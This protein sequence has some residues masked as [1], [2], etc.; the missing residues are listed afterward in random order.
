MKAVFIHSARLKRLLQ[1]QAN[2]KSGPTG[3]SA[4]N[5]DF[6]SSVKNWAFSLGI[7][8]YFIGWIYLHI[9]YK[10][11]GIDLTGLDIPVYYFFVY[12][13]A[14]IGTTTGLYYLLSVFLVTLLLSVLHS[15]IHGKIP[16][17]AVPRKILIGGVA[18][19]LFI[20]SFQLAR[21]RGKRD[22]EDARAGIGLNS[23]CLE[24]KASKVTSY[25][26]VF[27]AA[28][29]ECLLQLVTETKEKYYVVFQERPKDGTLPYGYTFEVP[30]IDVALAT[31]RLKDV[32]RRE[33][34]R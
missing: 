30:R 2:R 8:L 10:Y 13:Y 22:A 27:S 4:S 28:N 20:V 9:F 6:S 15:R 32:A 25:P 3:A 16:W 5:E 31:I 34:S 17:L 14:V 24:L 29:A 33:E 21:D 7:Y 11:L 26:Q 19:I 23:I 12:A 1:H 18:V